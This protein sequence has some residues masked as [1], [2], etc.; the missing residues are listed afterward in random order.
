M[1][2]FEQTSIPS[3]VA[4]GI[5]QKILSGELSAGERIVEYSL[6]KGIGV[7]QRPV[8][9]ALIQ[10]EHGGFVTRYPNRGT[11]VTQLTSEEVRQILQVRTPLE[12]LAITLAKK[13]INAI[14]SR[15]L[16]KATA[17]MSA[18]LERRL[19]GE[20]AEADY[21]FHE[22]VWKMTG[23]QQLLMILK[24]L[25]S[26]LFSFGITRNAVSG[27]DVLHSNLELHT[28]LAESLIHDDVETCQ[29]NMRKQMDHFWAKKEATSNQSDTPTVQAA[30]FSRAFFARESPPDQFRR[31]GGLSLP[32]A[33]RG[34]WRA[35][36]PV[37]MS[38]GANREPCSCR[39]RPAGLTR[40]GRHDLADTS[41]F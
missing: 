9:E 14:H 33:Q 32:L 27:W 11:I 5:R 28:S 37:P 38:F 18:A 31:F 2:E 26:R 40:P 20:F 23:N 10:L 17:K 13:N 41:N 30:H 15:L 19:A 1:P 21:A 6:A 35:P 3:R 34:M 39:E 7:S 29:E 22:T 36:Y 24:S 25:C 8:R 4:N 16:R 12:M